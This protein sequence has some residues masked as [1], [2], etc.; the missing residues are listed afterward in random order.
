MRHLV[1]LL[2][3]LS[4]AA[5]A[6]GSST[7][8]VAEA[9][10]TTLG[11]ESS[12]TEVEASTTTEAQTTTTESTT[13]TTEAAP[14]D[15]SSTDP[16]V[17]TY[18][19]TVDDIDTRLD[20]ADF[21]DPA[22]LEET[23]TYQLDAM[24]SIELPGPIADD[25][26]TALST[27][28]DYLALLEAVDFDVAAADE[29]ATALFESPEFT[30]AGENIDAFDAEFCPEQVD[31]EPVA[32]GSTLLLTE[33]D[34][35]ALLDSPEGREGVIGGMVDNTAMTPEEAN[36]FIDNT[37]PGVLASLFSLGTG[38]QADIDPAII[39]ELLGGLEACDL[40]L[41]ALG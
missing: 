31:D 35:V 11:E 2:I 41:G 9:T 18:C 19:A 7:E 38:D 32:D 24:G 33:D 4:L 6:C 1:S 20:A 40:S 36:C 28:T 15:L 3:V 27:T 14:Q 23:L 10:T 39:G 8:T 21:T 37:D 16:V 5:A 17:V 12:T 22:A 29:D 30:Q 34:V 25:I 13:T 26:V